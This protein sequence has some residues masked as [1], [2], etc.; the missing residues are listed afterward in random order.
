[1]PAVELPTALEEQKM[2]IYR[3]RIREHHLA[4][5]LQTKEKFQDVLAELFF[6]QNGGNMMDFISWKRKPPAMYLDYVKSHPLDISEEGTTLTCPASMPGMLI[7]LTFLVYLICFGRFKRSKK[8]FFNS[9]CYEF[10]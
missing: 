8:I 4:V 7:F 1:M 2:E 3:K 10:A 9:W 5:G 6:L